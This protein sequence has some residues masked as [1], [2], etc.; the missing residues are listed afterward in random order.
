MKWFILV[1]INE[2]PSGSY[3]STDR[4]LESQD[5]T[6]TPRASD[7]IVYLW[8]SHVGVGQLDI[9]RWSTLHV[10]HERFESRLTF[11]RSKAAKEAPLAREPGIYWSFVKDHGV[12]MRV[13]LMVNSALV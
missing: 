7:Q 9:C 3:C 5:Y 10:S 4:N 1:D 12:F 2:R 6:S 11:L 13:P 8:L